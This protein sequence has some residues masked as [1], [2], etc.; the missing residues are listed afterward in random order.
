MGTTLLIFAGIFAFFRQ[1]SSASLGSRRRW[2][3]FGV[4][5]G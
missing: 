5:G 3:F 1:A 4:L 2:F